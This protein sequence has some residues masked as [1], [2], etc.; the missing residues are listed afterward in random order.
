MFVEVNEVKGF[1]FNIDGFLHY[2]KLP[3]LHRDKVW[4]VVDNDILDRIKIFPQLSCLINKIKN[5]YPYRFVSKLL[6]DQILEICKHN[7]FSLNAKHIFTAT[8]DFEKSFLF[9]EPIKRARDD[10]NLLSCHTIYITAESNTIDKALK[11]HVGTMIFRY[12]SES[13]LEEEQVYRCGPDYILESP[14]ELE[15]VLS[16][17]LLGYMT[18]VHSCPHNM[19]NWSA[20]KQLIQFLELPNQDMPDNK[21][22]VGGRYF[23]CDDTRH[24]K[25]PLSIRIRNQKNYPERHKQLFS[26][27]LKYAAEWISNGKYDFITGVP[28]RVSTS[29]NRFKIYLEHIPKEFRDF[30]KSKIAPDLIRCVREYPKQT[31]AGSYEDRKRNVKDA[32]V[33]KGDVT[34]KVVVVVD[35]VITSGGTLYE[36]TRILMKAGCRKVYPVAL[37]LTVSSKVVN[38]EEPLRCEKCNGKLVPRCGTSTGYVFFGCENYF[39][40]GEH[41]KMELKDAVLLLNERTSPPKKEIPDD[42]DIP[43]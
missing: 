16:N 27:Q 37:S 13:S 42:F 5:K 39:Q 32:F 21:V 10:M 14:E 40:G 19:L 6:Q 29:Q 8:S 31:R 41:S 22:F 36:I 11:L 25:N 43:F 9:Y 12:K 34:G 1:V 26:R 2:G 24:A 15:K 33:V 35:D 38:G 4:S 3:Y 30:D 18:E 28:P 23:P 7:S 17:V 20:E